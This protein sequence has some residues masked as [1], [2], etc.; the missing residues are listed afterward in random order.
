MLG[1]RAIG[2]LNIESNVKAGF[3][4]QD[5]EVAELLAAEATL[6]ISSAN[7][8]VNTIELHEYSGTCG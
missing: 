2:V 6:A 1:D 7:H 8:Y 3:T 5:I 4:D